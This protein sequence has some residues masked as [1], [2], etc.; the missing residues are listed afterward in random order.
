MVIG[1][2]KPGLRLQIAGFS[3]MMATFHQ[4]MTKG[5]SC[6]PALCDLAIHRDSTHISTKHERWNFNMWNNPP[7]VFLGFSHVDICRRHSWY[8]A[9]AWLGWLAWEFAAAFQWI[10]THRYC[11]GSILQRL[12]WS[13]DLI[14]IILR[15]KSMGRYS[16]FEHWDFLGCWHR[17]IPCLRVQAPNRFD[18][19]DGC[20][21]WVFLIHLSSE[22]CAKWLDHASVSWVSTT[23]ITK[24]AT[25]HR[26]S[27]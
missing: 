2:K 27:V 16:K 11:W 19:D 13:K 8:S 23:P 6:D 21:D 14:Y 15:R 18:T 17:T 7:I 5:Q 22:S 20:E 12:W 24:K 3:S 1:T 4:V 26:L 25:N 10:S 9:L